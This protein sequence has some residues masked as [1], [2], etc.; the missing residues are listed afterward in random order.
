MN[1]EG[2]F[3]SIDRK[4]TATFLSYITEDATFRFGSAPAVQGHEAIRAAVDGFFGSIAGSQH[5]I[6]N[7]LSDDS[8]QVCEGEVTYTR[9]DNSELTLPFTNVFEIA[10]D[11]VSHYK[12]YIDIAPLYAG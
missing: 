5:R 9:H 6:L 10:D 12:I 2:L 11:R 8:T 7:T 4:D 3:K 1:L